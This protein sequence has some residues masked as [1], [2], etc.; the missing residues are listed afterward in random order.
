MTRN[1]PDS[2]DSSPHATALYEAMLGWLTPLAV[3][4]VISGGGR[5]VSDNHNRQSNADT[6]RTCVPYGGCDQG[7][8]GDVVNC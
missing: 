5:G 6:G 8:V 1:L 4:L 7:A 2:E 3:D